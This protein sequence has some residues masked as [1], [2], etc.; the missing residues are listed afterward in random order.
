MIYSQFMPNT[1]TDSN[2]IKDA[3]TF[4]QMKSFLV[5]RYKHDRLYGVAPWKEC[6]NY[7]D[8]VV[9]SALGYL[10]EHGLGCVSQ[11]EAASGNAVWY[12]F[13]DGGIQVTDTEAARVA[14]RHNARGSQQPSPRERGRVDQGRPV[15]HR[16]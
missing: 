13:K 1:N 7:G 3:P 11:F 5:E 9:N 8:V 15:S 4:E 6:P 12:V 2:A 14:L 10:A 16:E